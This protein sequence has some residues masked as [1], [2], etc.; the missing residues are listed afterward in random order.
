MLG[1]GALASHGVEDLKLVLVKR[2]AERGLQ[3]DEP[4]APCADVADPGTEQ[5]AIG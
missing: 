2:L 1:R 4:S 3:N 5:A